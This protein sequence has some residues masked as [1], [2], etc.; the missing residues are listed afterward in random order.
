MLSEGQRAPGTPFFQPLLRPE[1][2][3]R[4]PISGRCLFLGKEVWAPLDTGSQAATPA[5]GDQSR[6]LPLL[7]V[8]DATKAAPCPPGEQVPRKLA[9]TA[10]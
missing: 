4:A 3:P 9:I 2:P 6:L 8:S 5:F 10:N 1:W 7:R